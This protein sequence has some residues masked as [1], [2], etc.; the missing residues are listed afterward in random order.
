MGWVIRGVTAIVIAGRVAAADPVDDLAHEPYL[1]PHGDRGWWARAD[2][3]DAL[4]ARSGQP[5]RAA[6]YLA[7]ACAAR[8]ETLFDATLGSDD[9]TRA[10]E[11]ADRLDLVD[12]RTY[13]ASPL[14]SRSVLDQE[15]RTIPRHAR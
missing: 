15:G 5:A 4:A 8:S 3:D 6:R 12:V 14:G 7:M 1:H 11:L 9:C 13:L 10:R 2:D